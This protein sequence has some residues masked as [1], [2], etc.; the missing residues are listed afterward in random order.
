MCSDEIFLKH[1]PPYRGLANSAV[2]TQYV[3]TLA[4]LYIKKS[5]RKEFGGVLEFWG[6]I[7]LGGISINF[8][9]IEQ[10]L[11]YFGCD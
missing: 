4:Y 11:I 10:E 5:A 9:I 2:F 8:R 3:K 6:S 7:G 1:V